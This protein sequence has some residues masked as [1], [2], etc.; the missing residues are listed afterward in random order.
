[1]V[2]IVIVSHSRSLADG[3]KE[4]ASQMATG[5]NI[6]V[7]G[8]TVDG[9]LGTDIEKIKDAISR[10]YSNDGVIIL[11]DLGSSMMNTEMAIEFLRE[12]MRNNIIMLDAPLVE[13]AVVAAVDASIGR[14]LAE[15]VADLNKMKIN[16]IN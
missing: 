3:V 1:M 14:S 15:I 5:V 6:Q 11:F 16:K 13:G 8:G 10:A 4:V 12:N 2:G 7:A 9:R